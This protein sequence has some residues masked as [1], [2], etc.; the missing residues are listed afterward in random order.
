MDE[1]TR[2]TIGFYDANAANYVAETA[3]VE[4]G[5]LQREF[6]QRLPEGGRVLDLGCGSGRDSLAFLKAGFEVDAVDGSAQMVEAA[7]GLTG[8]P[9][10]HAFFTDYEPKGPLRRHLGVQQPA[11]RAGAGASRRHLQVRPGPQARRLLLPQLQA[12]SPRRYARRPLVHRPRRARPA[13]PCR[14]G[15]RAQGRPRRRHGRRP[16][17]PLRREVAQRLVREGVGRVGPHGTADCR[18]GIDPLF[19]GPCRAKPAPQ[20]GPSSTFVKQ[21]CSTDQIK[22]ENQPEMV[23]PARMGPP[24]IPKSVRSM[25]STRRNSSAAK[26]SA[27]PSGTES[28]IAFYGSVR[29]HNVSRASE[30]DS[31][32]DAR[33]HRDAPAC[34]LEHTAS[35]PRQQNGV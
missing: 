24:S 29:D 20:N 10:A 14:R 18:D 17:R 35:R 27:R 11:P 6:A 16:P 28:H 31:E 8:L 12:G 25:Y 3:G 32:P 34:T 26:A 21:S 19:G 5:A 7:S 15:S 9:V 4:F 22:L 1:S 13:R 2:K 23:H 33:H 30:A